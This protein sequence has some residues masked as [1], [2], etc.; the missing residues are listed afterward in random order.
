MSKIELYGSPNSTFVRTA[1]MACEEKGVA[2]EI[3]SVGEGIADLKKPDH[4][5]RHPFG[6]I[7]AMRHGDVQLFETAAI[8]VYIDAAFDGP[9]LSPTDPVERARLVQ[10]VSAINDYIVPTALR[11][12]VAVIFAPPG[13]DV[14]TDEKKIQAMRPAIH[15][16]IRILDEGLEGRTYSGRRGDLHRR[17]AARADPALS[18]QHAGRAGVL[19]RARE[20]RPLVASGQQTA[21][22]Q[23]HRAA[24]P[25]QGE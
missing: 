14:E 18:R 25:G 21:E 13:L 23:E 15:D 3:H 20:Y 8:C 17:P 10:W 24:L 19:R 1:C 16:Q 9:A 2:Y 7:P 22:L 6:K 4:L 11:G 12:Y 5:A